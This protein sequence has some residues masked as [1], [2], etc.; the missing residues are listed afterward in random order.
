MNRRIGAL[1]AAILGVIL[2]VET[3]YAQS[4]GAIQITQVAQRDSFL[5]VFFDATDA[6]G[7]AIHDL[8]TENTAIAIGSAWIAG[9]LQSFPASGEGIALV[10]VVDLSLSSADAR[11]VHA[12]RAL[13]SYVGGMN[14]K[15]SV[16]IVAVGDDVWVIQ[17]FTNDKETLIAAVES[18]QSGRYA[19]P[20]RDG[21]A[22]AVD[23]SKRLDAGLPVRRAIAVVG[24]GVDDGASATTPDELRET[25]L[26]AQVPMFAF[27]FVEA[28]NQ[29]ALNEIGA[30]A[31]A[32]NGGFYPIVSGDALD[33]A[34]TAVRSR[35]Q[36]GYRFCATLPDGLADGLVHGISLRVT[37][38]NQTLVDAA[39]IRLIPPPQPARAEVPVQASAVPELPDPTPVPAAV[40][41]SNGWYRDPAIWATATGF[42]FLVAALVLALFAH[43]TPRRTTHSTSNRHRA[44]RRSR[45]VDPAFAT[46]TAP[47][48]H[49]EITFGESAFATQTSAKPAFTERSTGRELTLSFDSD[50]GIPLWLTELNAVRRRHEIRLID[51]VTIG[52]APGRNAVVLQDKTVSACHCELRYACGILRARDLKSQNG[53]YLNDKRVRD[54][55]IVQSGDTLQLGAT[56]LLVY[57]R[58][59]P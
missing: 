43:R 44:S 48:T 21:V 40:S 35:V 6:S 3:V 42:L 33:D 58:E 9:N 10:C 28:A 1:I 39:E 14:D 5:Y 16:A 19:A 25:L 26:Q 52:R 47:S 7:A 2:F 29:T 46:F 18:L 31:R 13:L 53:T 51:I 34:Y 30:L 22:C 11:F 24:D 59:L 36:S 54:A 4:L 27:G 56:K 15:D 32:S 20:F 41:D 23:L 12:K 45:P 37:V 8:Q 49:R 55:V 57:M 17:D 50:I 38:G